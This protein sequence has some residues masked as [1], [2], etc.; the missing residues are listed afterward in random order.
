MIYKSRAL[1]FAFRKPEFNTI[2]YTYSNELSSK[3]YISALGVGG[4]SEENAYFPYV[5]RGVGGLEAK[6]LYCL[7]KG[8]KFLFT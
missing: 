2:Y 4:G 7:C 6:C 8:S 1:D 5:V 3:Y